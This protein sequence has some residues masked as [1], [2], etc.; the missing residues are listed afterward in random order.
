MVE[1]VRMAAGFASAAG[2]AGAKARPQAAPF[3]V[4]RDEP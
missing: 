1:Y 4:R 2:A 3:P